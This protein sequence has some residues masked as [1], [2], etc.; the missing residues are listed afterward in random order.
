MAHEHAA[1]LATEFNVLRK[2]AN[3]VIKLLD[4]G[5]TIPFIARYRK[6]MTG[7]MDEVT[8]RNIEIRHKA[9]TELDERKAFIINAIKEQGKLTAEL[10]ERILTTLDPNTLEDIYVPF[11]PRR[12]TRA[13]EARSQGL[14]PL[15][16]LLLD[17]RPGT[18][19][20]KA[21][22][23]YLNDTVTTAEE[24]LAGASDIIAEWV[25]E[26]EKARSIVRAKYNRS[27]TI[28]SR[29]VRGKEEEGKNYE[30]YFDFTEPL[31]LC[32]SHR[33]LAMRR[34][35]AEGILRVS[36]TIDD[37]EMGDRLCRMFVRQSADETTSRLLIQAVKDGYK[38]LMKPSIENETAAAFKEKSDESAISMFADNVRQL[39]MGAPLG[40]RRVLAIDPGYRTGCKVVCLDEQGNL[41]HHDVIYPC[42]PHNDYYNSADAICG[43][44]DH[45]RIGAIAIGNGTA[46]RDTERF[47]NSL[48]FSHKVEIFMVNESGASIYSASEVARRE[49]PDQDVTVRGAVSIGRRL[50]DPL[51]ELVKIDPKSIG[52]GQYQH[53]VNQS[54][55]KEALDYTVESCV[56]AVG[57]NVNTASRELLSYVSGI[58][59]QLASNIV[60]YRAQ[61]GDF[62]SRAELMNVP[63]MGEKTFQQCA[64]FLRIPGAANILDNTGVHP[65]RYAL[66][67][68]MAAD[69]NAD[70]NRLV[71]DKFLRDHLELANYVTRE[72]GMPTLTDIVREL[73]K[74]G[75]DP[76]TKAEEVHYD[77]NVRTLDDLH[78]GMTLQGKVTN[79]TSFGV[80]VDIGLKENGLIHISQLSD[81]FISNPREVVSVGQLVKARVI[82]ID[83]AR[84]R[85]ALTLK[86]VPQ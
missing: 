18:K 75:R 28:S 40:H 35:Q 78:I 14:E 73:E 80:F 29:V 84:G 50:I 70:V 4:D 67:E 77:E 58:G 21:A 52:V 13:A 85:I 27:A 16:R 8:L 9:L 48:Q 5:A 2:H 82:D 69:V 72:T 22:T 63:R 45:F 79:M 41:M 31:R 51:A 6:E 46:G 15:A 64:G 26:N 25:A 44:V 24:A 3:A 81:R 49:F 17:Q 20:E 60:E 68:K 43:M 10:K 39:L 11:K 86:N 38:R 36:I 74:P 37:D 61:H 12:R 33:Y 7:S 55:L 56:N 32:S 57:V 71:S 23:K 66:V 19:P 30:N 62:K 53:D 1:I 54:K 42:A 65:E 83:I 34:G 76:R 47:V 59:D